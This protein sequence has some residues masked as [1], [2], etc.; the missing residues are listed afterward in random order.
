[1]HEQKVTKKAK[2]GPI[3]EFSGKMYT[4]TQFKFPLLYVHSSLQLKLRN[5]V[6]NYLIIIKLCKY[7]FFFYEIIIKKNTPYLKLNK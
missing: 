7:C 4:N 5:T 3:Y 2:I 6:Y 1:M